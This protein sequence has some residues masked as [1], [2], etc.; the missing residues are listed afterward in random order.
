M[1]LFTAIICS[2]IIITSCTKSKLKQCDDPNCE[3]YLQVWEQLFKSRNA[4]SDAYFDK[5]IKVTNTAISTWNSGE[6]FRVSYNV[7]IDW[8]KIEIQDQFII[9]INKDD[10]R[11]PTL[12]VRKG[13]YLNEEELNEVVEILAYNSAITKVAPLTKL[14]YSSKKKAVNALQKIA[15]SNK[16]KFEGLYFERPLY[17]NDGSP[18]LKGSGTIDYDEN[19]CISGSIN[20]A[21]GEGEA[22]EDVCWKD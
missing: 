16:I 13:E 9:K 10:E 21:T 2:L 5:H 11:Y 17:N 20:L 15:G 3:T 4:I 1:R 22:N 8:A 12:K 18:Y 19:K 14:K 7:A 6:S